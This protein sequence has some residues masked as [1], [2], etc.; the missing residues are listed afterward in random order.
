MK[1][2]LLTNRQM[3][4]L[5]FR[6]EGMSQVDIACLFG[7][8]PQNI[9]EIEHRAWKNI[10]LAI[11]TMISYY[12]LDARFLCTLKEGSDLFDSAALIFEEGKRIGI[13]VT[14]GAVDL[15][16]RLQKENPYRISGQLIRKDID[17]YLRDDGDIYSG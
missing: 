14:L 8:S 2:R 11:N 12:T 13:P 6:L 1:T 5:R 16:N 10:E 9:M 3:V 15:I 4:V 17:V 7:T